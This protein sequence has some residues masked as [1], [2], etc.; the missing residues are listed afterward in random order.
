[1]GKRKGRELAERED[2]DGE[3]RVRQ[4]EDER[5]LRDAVHPRADVGDDLTAEE[6]AVVAVLADAEEGARAGAKD[7]CRHASSASS[8]FVRG[9][10]AV[11]IASSSPGSSS[12]SRAESQ[13]VAYDFP[14]RRILWPAAESDNPTR[15][16]S[17]STAA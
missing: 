1:A 16:C 10:I 5:R 2:H 13:A 14:E 12:R 7:R 6:E 4:R 15:R 11:S 8:R 17:P 9:S 3:G